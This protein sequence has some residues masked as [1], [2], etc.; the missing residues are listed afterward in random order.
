M[1]RPYGAPTHTYTTLFDTETVDDKVGGAF[2]ELESDFEKRKE[3]MSDPN[4]RACEARL[5]I[6]RRTWQLLLDKAD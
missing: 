4:R 1:V 2:K 3:Y 6:L 5:D